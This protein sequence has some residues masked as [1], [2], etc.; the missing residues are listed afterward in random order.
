VN[1]R[2]RKLLDQLRD[3]PEC[4]VCGCINIGGNIVPAHSNQLRDG[5]GVGIKAH[6]YRSAA[7]CAACHAE[8]DQGKNW[9]KE[10]RLR[11]WEDAHRKTMAWL[12][13]SG[14]LVVK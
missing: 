6:D 8:I 13:E 1:F 2:S 11:V 4:F 7:V 9:S 10:E 12:I 14:K 5:K 3:A